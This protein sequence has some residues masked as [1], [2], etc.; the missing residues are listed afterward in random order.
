M[1]SAFEAEMP[2]LSF[3]SEAPAVFTL[4]FGPKWADKYLIT[5]STSAS[6]PLA[7]RD[8]ISSP[9]S[10]TDPPLVV[11]VPVLGTPSLSSSSKD[12]SGPRHATSPEF[13][14]TATIAP[15]GGCW[16][17]HCLVPSQK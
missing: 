4:I 16:Q 17:G 7:P 2:R 11:G 13:T 3:K 10:A 9:T 5:C 14:L 6:V 15:H 8:T 12:P 1:A